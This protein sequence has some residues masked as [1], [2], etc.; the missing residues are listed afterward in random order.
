MVLTTI[1]P[2]SWAKRISKPYLSLTRHSNN[3]SKASKI[4]QTYSIVKV[5]SEFSIPVAKHTLAKLATLSKSTL[6]NI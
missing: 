1:S 5:F 3:Y 2:K 6:K 4:R